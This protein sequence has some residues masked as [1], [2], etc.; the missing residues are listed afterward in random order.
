MAQN[1]LFEFVKGMLGGGGQPAPA[2]P[3][4]SPGGGGPRYEAPPLRQADPDDTN[5]ATIVRI[6]KSTDGRELIMTLGLGTFLVDRETPTICYY[7]QGAV[8]LVPTMELRHLCDCLMDKRNVAAYA[9]QYVDLLNVATYEIESR[10]KRRTAG[11]SR[12]PTPPPKPQP[13]P[14]KL[15]ARPVQQARW[16]DA[17]NPA[18]ITRVGRSNNGG[19]LIMTLGLGTFV[20]HREKPDLKYFDRGREW[21]I[22]E[23][24][25]RLLVDALMAKQEM[26]E[27]QYAYVDLLNVASF[28]QDRRKSR[29][30]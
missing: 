4:R 29:K 14:R 3:R 1:N 21:D 9:L 2:M 12:T 27:F 26:K 6:G 25:L 13:P 30:R 11:N 7:Q 16:P 28:L 22:Q 18:T 8:A 17:E 23:A 10:S 5:P 15:V 24:D 19:E 20:L